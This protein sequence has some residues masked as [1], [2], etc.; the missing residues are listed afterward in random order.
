[1]RDKGVK[2]HSWLHNQTSGQ[3]KIQK[4][5][6]ASPFFSHQMKESPTDAPFF[7]ATARRLFAALHRGNKQIIGDL[8]RGKWSTKS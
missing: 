2:I 1:M 4:S 5:G 7:A 6:I 8:V 3:L